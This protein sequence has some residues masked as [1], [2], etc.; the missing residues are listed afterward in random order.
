MNIIGLLVYLVIAVIVFGFAWWVVTNYI[1]E[2]MR[3]FA[4]LILALIGVIFIVYILLNVVGG[5]GISLPS[6]RLHN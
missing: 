1:P 5:A 3:R 6:P 2:P 4:V